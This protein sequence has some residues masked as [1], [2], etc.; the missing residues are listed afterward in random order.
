MRFVRRRRGLAR[1]PQGGDVDRREIFVLEAIGQGGMGAV[2][3][4]DHLGLGTQVAVKF[5]NEEV[6]QNAQSVQRFSSE[7]TSIRSL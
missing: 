6:A 4:A 3:V 7:A 5:M 2:W 1:P